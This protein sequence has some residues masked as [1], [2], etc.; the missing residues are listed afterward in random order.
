MPYP[1]ALLPH[2]FSLILHPSFF[3]PYLY[4]LNHQPPLSYLI[5]SL[6]PHL[7][8]NPSFPL[9]PN[10]QPSS[11][12]PHPTSQIHITHDTSRTPQTLS[13]T[14]NPSSLIPQP[15]SLRLSHLISSL[16]QAPLFLIPHLLYQPPSIILYT[17]C[18]MSHSSCPVP[19]APHLLF[20]IPC[21]SSL[22]PNPSSLIIIP[23]TSTLF[24]SSH[25][26]HLAPNPLFLIP[27]PFPLTPNP[28]SLYSTV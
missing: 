22:F 2:S 5:S 23:Y 3:V 9:S 28:S 7:F 17:S 13:L 16:S 20:L 6:T 14:P 21:P 24:L 4:S 25:P 10:S 1:S 27:H 11:L 12:I 18:I 26:S 15:S 8:A 19:Y